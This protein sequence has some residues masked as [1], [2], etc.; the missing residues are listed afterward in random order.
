MAEFIRNNFFCFESLWKPNILQLYEA[1]DRG[2]VYLENIQKRNFFLRLDIFHLL[3][4]ENK[5][6][7]YLACKIKK[8]RWKNLVAIADDLLPEWVTGSLLMISLLRFLERRLTIA[9]CLS[10]DDI[11]EIKT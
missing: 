8:F 1:S 2:F 7:R 5:L 11:M 10:K 4:T 6:A 3:L 9:E